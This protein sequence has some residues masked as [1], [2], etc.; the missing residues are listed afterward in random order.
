MFF[1]LL[2]IASLCW[3]LASALPVAAPQ[4]IP[5]AVAETTIHTEA[6]PIPRSAEAITAPELVVPV[7]RDVGIERR[8]KPTNQ[9]AVM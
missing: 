2:I 7:E 9:C 3:G 4:P 1:S 5:A 6:I 8:I